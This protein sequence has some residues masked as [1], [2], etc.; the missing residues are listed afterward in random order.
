MKPGVSLTSIPSVSS[1]LH[2]V[3]IASLAPRNI[4]KFI[5]FYII[6]IRI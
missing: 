2:D 5:N 1:V 3:V 6:K 4:H